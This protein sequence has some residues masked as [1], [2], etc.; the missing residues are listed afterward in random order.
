MQLGA[1]G[2]ADAGQ[3][4]ALED[5]G[6]DLAS[7]PQLG[8][9]LRAQ[10]GGEGAGQGAGV[11]RRLLGRVDAAVGRRGE[12]G[13]ELAAGAG[14][15]P[16]G[17]ELERAL[18][19]V[20]A[21]QL[22]RLVAVEGYV[23]GAG[24]GVP[25][26]LAAGGLELGDELGVEPRRGE[27]QLQQLRL[28]EGEL[29]DRRQHPGGDVGRPRRRFGPLQDEDPRPA[30]GGPP[31]A[32]EADHSATY[33]YRVETSPIGHSHC[34]RRHYP[35]QVQTVGGLDATLS[36]LSGSRYPKAT[37]LPRCGRDRAPERGVSEESRHMWRGNSD[38][39]S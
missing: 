6:E 14:G 31:G 35:D 4:L 12:A 13:L 32:G 9:R 37:P 19:L 33:E 30:L 18:Q 34:L 24:P 2:G 22:R 16:L 11:D 17:L 3:A 23:E 1:V 15:E 39:P 20:D 26:R 21:V 8:A 38:T 29:A 5:A 36:A 28:A 25:G 10:G 7:R 27:G